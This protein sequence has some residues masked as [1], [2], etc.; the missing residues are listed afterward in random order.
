M[1]AVR[2]H[3]M[4]DLRVQNHSRPGIP[5]TA[6]EKELNHFLELAAFACNCPMA[7]ISFND[8]GKQKLKATKN[9]ASSFSPGTISFCSDVI[10]QEDV[11]VLSGTPKEKQNSSAIQFYAGAPIVN[12]EGRRS[13][14]LCV[15]DTRPD[16]EFTE[17]Q[18]NALKTIAHL[19]ACLADLKVNKDEA[20]HHA[21]EAEKRM[22]HLAIS[23]QDSERGFIA[24]KLQ[25]N[26][27]QTLAATKLYLEF[28]VNSKDKKDHF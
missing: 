2:V 20:I 6:Q 9:L 24:H 3:H 27:A 25:E 23:E 21:I 15:M 10:L 5:D 28:A 19:V 12:T 17:Q 1:N 18:K 14:S 13:G 16:K 7:A 8:R 4:E 26:F 11:L 22:T